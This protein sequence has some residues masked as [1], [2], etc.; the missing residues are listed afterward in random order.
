[1]FF[2][3][4]PNI[5]VSFSCVAISKTRSMTRNEN[6]DSSSKNTFKTFDN[7]SLATWSDLHH[8]ILFLVMMQL[9]VL[10]FTPFSG[11]CKWWRSLAIS[12]K[13]KFMETRPLTFISIP[14]EPKEEDYSYYLEDIE[15]RSLTSILPHSGGRKCVGFTCD[16]LILFGSKTNDLWLIDPITRHGIHFPDIPSSVSVDPKRIKDFLVFSPSMFGWVFVMTDG[17]TDIWFSISGHGAW[18]HVSSTF[19]ILDLHVFKGKMYAID[20]SRHLYELTLSPEPKLT[21]L[22]TENFPIFSQHNFFTSTDDSLILSGKMS[23]RPCKAY[24]LDFEEMKWVLYKT[25]K[26]GGE[27]IHSKLM[28]SAAVKHGKVEVYFLQLMVYPVIV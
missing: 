28:R 1:M 14:T 11:V 8:D 17:S 19:P 16:H 12:N 25:C 24:K 4:H 5:Y 9:G 18:R 10:D 3:K 23:E 15:E 21:L 22:E 6:Q 26:G 20:N 27:C 2:T 13:S 7:D